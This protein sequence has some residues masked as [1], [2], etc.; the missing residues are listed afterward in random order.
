MSKEQLNNLKSLASSIAHESRNSLDGIKGSCEIVKENLDEIVQFVALMQITANR[1][2]LINEM[3]LK[4]IS[5]GKI[6]DSNFKNL[7]IA[8]IVKTAI[9]EYSFQN[10][11]EKNLININLENDFTFFG[12][13]TLMI[14]VLFNLLKNALHYRVK[15]DIWLDSANKQL[16]FKD[17]GIGIPPDKLPHIFDSF[18]TSNKKGGTGLGLPFC[19]RAMEAFGGDISCKSSENQGAEFCLKF[20]NL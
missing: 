15:I 19:K 12:D 8:K 4:N 17:E 6:D 14:Y 11:D 5:D 3:I 1:G 9:H 16:H 2:L 13:E 7:S 20:S 10:Q 18:F